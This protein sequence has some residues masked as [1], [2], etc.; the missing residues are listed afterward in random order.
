MKK[1]FGGWEF[2]QFSGHVQSGI[3][4][5]NLL[6]ALLLAEVLVGSSLPPSPNGP[7]MPSDCRH[8]SGT[9]KISSL[10]FFVS[11]ILGHCYP[12]SIFPIIHSTLSFLA[13]AFRCWCTGTK[14]SALGLH[15]PGGTHII[16]PHLSGWLWMNPWVD[17]D[18]A[19]VLNEQLICSLKYKTPIH[20][21]QEC[22]KNLRNFSNSGHIFQN[23]CWA[24]WKCV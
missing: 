10:S 3:I 24:Y 8:C 17:S 16:Y 15:L 14:L 13:P 20:G 21:R 2:G 4:L 22:P 7:A 23:F 12:P 18:G 9:W 5:L 19:R 6:A 11:Y 1:L